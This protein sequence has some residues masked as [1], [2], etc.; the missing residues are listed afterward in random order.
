MMRIPKS[1]NS[2]YISNAAESAPN[3]A[4]IMI[5]ETL[6]DEDDEVRQNSPRPRAYGQ[7]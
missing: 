1:P 2:E 6:F 4:Q 5:E 3:I 7:R